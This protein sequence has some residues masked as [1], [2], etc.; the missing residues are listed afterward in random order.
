MKQQKP[1]IPVHSISF[2]DALGILNQELPIS[3]GLLLG[4]F[5]LP[6]QLFFW[7]LLEWKT[8][9]LFYTDA[10][11]SSSSPVFFVFPLDTSYV[12]ASDSES[13]IYIP[14]P[15]S[16]SPSCLS[17][18]YL[19]ALCKP[20]L[21]QPPSIVQNLLLLFHSYCCSFSHRQQVYFS[22]NLTIKPSF[23]SSLNRVI[24]ILYI[25]ATLWD[26]FP[27]SDVQGMLKNALPFLSISLC[28]FK[29]RKLRRW[30][31]LAS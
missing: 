26:Q 12:F 18:D 4:S 23:A 27:S 11:S 20:G 22:L 13:G 21:L 6:L 5:T 30:V 8:E 17:Q 16:P 2:L 31:I 10:V 15:P 19:S 1:Q 25:K 28:I 9:N 3:C 24:A 7:S 14:H 29:V